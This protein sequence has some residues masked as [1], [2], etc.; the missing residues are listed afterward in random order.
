MSDIVL[1]R[2]RASESYANFVFSLLLFEDFQTLLSPDLIY[3]LMNSSGA[4]E[5]IADEK[6]AV[7]SAD[8]LIVT[9]DALAA[10]RAVRLILREKQPKTVF[11]ADAAIT[12][13]KKLVESEN[14]S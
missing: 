4:L 13:L 2:T 9:R 1:I 14:A 8:L 11:V 10:A 3:T 12:A 7:P 6:S 5:E